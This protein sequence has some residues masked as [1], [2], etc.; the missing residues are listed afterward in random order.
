MPLKNVLNTLRIIH[1]ALTMGL[2]VFTLFVF[3][4][5]NSFIARMDNE[6]FF[7]YLVPLGGAIGYFLGKWLFTKQVSVIAKNEPLNTK[8]A[9]YQSA[10]LIKFALLEA[11]A[12][13]ALFAYYQNGNALHL[14]IALFLITYLVFQHPTLKRVISHLDLAKD[15]IQQLQ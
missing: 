9:R 14:T 15:E 3:Y 4:R 7:T 8:L 1:G 10:S 6:D 2:I 11:P 12:F 13:L 5:A